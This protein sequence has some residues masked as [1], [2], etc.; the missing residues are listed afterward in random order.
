MESHL[1]AKSRK[2]LEP[3]SFGQRVPDPNP[4]ASTTGGNRPKIALMSHG[5]KEPQLRSDFG[6]TTM[7]VPKKLTE[8]GQSVSPSPVVNPACSAPSSFS[9]AVYTTYF[10][11]VDS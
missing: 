5:Q 6:W 8:V 11:E 7:Q 9:M 10:A 2:G 3:I 4:N 1:R